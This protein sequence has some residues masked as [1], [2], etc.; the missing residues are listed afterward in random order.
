MSSATPLDY[1]SEHVE[2]VGLWKPIQI[3]ERAQ[4]PLQRLKDPNAHERGCFNLDPPPVNEAPA[5]AGYWLRLCCCPVVI[6]TAVL[7]QIQGMIP[8]LELNAQ[9]MLVINIADSLVGAP[10]VYCTY[11][12]LMFYLPNRAYYLQLVSFLAMEG[13]VKR[14]LGTNRTRQLTLVL[15]TQRRMVQSKF[16][17]WVVYVAQTYLFYFGA[18]FSFQFEW[19]GVLKAGSAELCG[20]PVLPMTDASAGSRCARPDC[21]SLREELELL[22]GDLRELA[23]E[24][25]ALHDA[26]AAKDAD[27]QRALHAKD[28][29][30]ARLQLE[31]AAVASAVAPTASPSSTTA[32]TSPPPLSNEP[33]TLQLQRNTDAEAENWARE[34]DALRRANAALE[35]QLAELRGADAKDAAAAKYAADATSRD[36]KDKRSELVRVLQENEQLRSEKGELAAALRTTA[37][38]ARENE[39][40]VQALYAHQ[41]AYK[42]ALDEQTLEIT[43]VHA[44][45]EQLEREKRQ[46]E[47][48]LLEMDERES[49][50]ESLLQ[51]ATKKH[52]AERAALRNELVATQRRVAELEQRRPQQQ[53][54]QPQPSQPTPT[55]A[56]GDDT[57]EMERQLALLQELRVRDKATIAE[58][59]HR[60]AQQQSDLESLSEHVDADAAVERAV[61][62]AV[63]QEEAASAG[64]R[65]EHSS[66]TRRLREQSA[67]LRDVEARQALLEQELADARAWN[68][69]YERRAGLEDVMACQKQLRKQL[70]AERQA[71]AALRQQ[72][73]AQLEATGKC[74]AAF[75]RLKAESGK[76]ADFQYDDL[77]LEA[78]RQ[79]ELAA[80]RAVLAQLEQQLEELE[81][82]RVRLL[83]RLREQARAAGHQRYE[84]HGVSAEQ[85]RLVEEFIDCVRH[86]PEVARRWLA[87]GPALEVTDG[88]SGAEPEPLTPDAVD[89]YK[90]EIAVAY[91]DNRK[92][93]DEVNGLRSALEETQRALAAARERADDAGTSPATRDAR[94]SSA[95]DELKQIREQIQ[96][97]V[98]EQ[99]QQRSERSERL[100]APTVVAAEEIA[101]KEKEDAAAVALLSSSSEGDEDVNVPSLQAA[102]ES[103]WGSVESLA[104]AVAKALEDKLALLQR[105]SSQQQ[106]SPPSASAA[107]GSSSSSGPCDARHEPPPTDALAF[108]SEAELTRQLDVLAELNACLDELVRAEAQNDALQQQLAQH[109]L[110]FR[111]VADQH[112]VLYQHFFHL[113]AAH[114]AR[115]DAHTRHAAELAGDHRALQLKC[116]RLEA[117]LRR[118]GPEPPEPPQPWGGAADV[119]TRLRAEV[120]ALTRAAAAHEANESRFRRQYAQLHREREAAQ[121]RVAALEADWLAM[122]RTLK[123]RVLYLESW[124]QGADALVA[125]LEAALAGSVRRSV[126]DRHEHVALEALRRL[127]ALSEAHAELRV[128]SA[129]LRS[130]PLELSRVQHENALLRACDSENGGA[131]GE[132][133]GGRGTDSV[134]QAR[135]AQLE[136]E[137]AAQCERVADVEAAADRRLQSDISGALAPPESDVAKEENALLVERVLELEQLYESLARACAKYKDVAAL[138]AG[139]ANTLARRAAQAAATR[140]AQQ[141]ERVRELLAASADH[142]VVGQLQHQ[143]VQVKTNYQHF[144]VKYDLLSVDH[145]Q[146]AIRAQHLE[147]ELEARD[148]LL[149]DARDKARSHVAVL[150]ATLAQA[151]ERDLTVRNAKWDAFRKR[152]DALDAAL[153]LETDRRQALE[154]ELEAA[155]QAPLPLPLPTAWGHSAQAA[156]GASEPL[157]M[158]RLQ[159]RVDALETRERVL[160]GQL[161]R[162]A[163]APEHGAAALQAE[164]AAAK[165][166]NADVLQQLRRAQTRV[167]ELLAENGALAARCQQAASA[168]EDLALELQHAHAQLEL[169]E[170]GGGGDGSGDTGNQPPEAASSPLMR[171]KVGLYERDQADLQQAAQAT[172]ASLKALVAEKNVQLRAAQ[173]QTQAA[174]RAA[175]EA[176]AQ[177]RVEAAQRNKQLFDEHQ[178]AIAQL[179]D[180]AAT[181]QRLERAGAGGASSGKALAAAQE[182][183]EHALREWQAAAAALEAAR[184]AIAD[185]DAALDAL[186]H[187]RDVAEAR[188][189]DALE[190]IVLSKEAMDAEQRARA[191]LEAQL[192]R[193]R[194]DVAAKARKLQL[195]RDAVVALKEEFLK[196]EDRHAVELAKA[197]HAVQAAAAA[198]SRRHK[199]A[200]D[201]DV[202]NDGEQAQWRE[203]KQRLEAQVQILQEKLALHATAQRKKRA[204]ATAAADEH[205]RDTGDDSA[206]TQQ[207]LEREVERLKRVVKER[208]V[209]EARAVDALAKKL[210]VL[211]A[212]NKALREARVMTSSVSRATG[213]NATSEHATGEHATSERAGPEDDEPPHDTA[214][215]GDDATAG[216]TRAQ[217]AAQ[218]KLQ[219][220][221]E[222]LAARVAEKQHALD[223]QAAQL[224]QTTERLRAAQQEAAQLKKAEQKRAATAAAAA[225]SA[226]PTAWP[227]SATAQVDDLERQNRYLQETLVLKRRE[228]EDAFAEQMDR[229]ERE[230][231][232][233]RLRLSQHGVSPASALASDK[234]HG[235]T[236][237]EQLRREETQFLLAQEASDELVLLGDELR[238]R[239][240][241][242]LAHDTRAMGT[243]LELET[244]RLE[245]RRLQRQCAA[246]ESAQQQQPQP[247][248]GRR[249]GSTPSAA[250]ATGAGG[251]GLRSAA[252]ERQALEDVVETMKRVIEKLRAEN[253]R[254]K[255][256]GGASPGQLEQL[257]RRLKEHRSAREQLEG[258]VA[259]LRAEAAELKQDKLRLQHK[260]RVATSTL[261][262]TQPQLRPPE[263][264][265]SDAALREAAESEVRELRRTVAEREAL[266]GELQDQL[267]A[268]RS[269]SRDD[270]SDKDAETTV[271]VQEQRIAAL[272]AENAKL[273]SE[274]S[275]FDAEFFE[276]IEDLKFQYAEA[277]RAKQQL[278]RALAVARTRDGH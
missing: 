204:T 134:L 242:L 81:A 208:A 56:A 193:V 173:T 87:A 71:S 117:C 180:A 211:E 73:S 22:R 189:G 252:Q 17:V 24:S 176:Q 269:S 278:E 203:V 174:R 225:A 149:S 201:G 164:L 175:A 155:Q 140:D 265:A 14:Q 88:S 7:V 136:R 27:A 247:Q 217:W 244:T 52:E 248:S 108:E 25:D 249:T 36:A 19:R 145:H 197:Q 106:Q 219:R 158:R 258:D 235:R 213:E 273:Q 253:E 166:L 26:L 15:K 150:E 119:E 128:Q 246:L 3:R 1:L 184:Q 267:A 223:A 4:Y 94:D 240:Q 75:E 103:S 261:T 92:L 214:T 200:K 190:E 44:Q 156:S 13:V 109:E 183:H 154:A 188:A 259:R 97:L 274:L 29:E 34:C 212:Q 113:H 218:K 85:W 232:R 9:T 33:L 8:G 77:V 167:S 263:A 133:L 32:I 91:A 143:L 23:A 229:Y 243:A 61:R 114:A 147:L 206:A 161:E 74:V 45:L 179:K 260:L 185:R 111:A 129:Q 159:A 195:L 83:Q 2:F 21:I 65:R 67:L 82:D 177:G 59:R 237:P 162:A 125:R 78:A 151:K 64:V 170:G 153:R 58:L 54:P 42:D 205:K 37:D 277:V 144:L 72:L 139:Q 70:A 233:L 262:A 224:A 60:V 182:R 66:L 80:S 40:L 20:G 79:G 76:P 152:L 215:G 226:M 234:P 222:L 132:A 157:A 142:A 220:R 48:A 137:L 116:E 38:A 236:A 31:L 16:V 112:T 250:S 46:L 256:R 264:I 115:N 131:V 10:L 43:H 41:G 89:A 209:G 230:L 110:A 257:R 186:R 105:A 165:A 196:A 169:L 207:A 241:E 86:T 57:E 231:R 239:E 123:C 266:I 28:Q 187:E 68:A 104:M 199:A 126:A 178:R 69:K 18:D 5:S 141:E 6:S 107:D 120:A 148:A 95:S 160:V 96:L 245:L 172:V 216:R 98:R 35:T 163:A 275:A 121:A 251:G 192:A 124:K 198:Q 221:A 11:K 181:I 49:G 39:A 191:Q 102:D 254:L 53:Q 100:E 122:E 255:T 210:R 62:A 93:A 99:E 276:E 130:L 168:N 146:V 118:W 138:A 84:A 171:R 194:R 228:W 135:I 270:D 50:A 238:R 127:E 272:A 271:Q 30:I 268:L 51:D 101:G 90:A 55:A 47:A 63:A 12:L 227:A 202:G